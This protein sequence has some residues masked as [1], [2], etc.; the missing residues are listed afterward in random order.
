[1]CTMCSM[2]TARE[3]LAGRGGAW[4]VVVMGGCDGGVGYVGW[5]VVM[6]LGGVCWML[7]YIG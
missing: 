1:M 5:V 7:A 4:W 2:C 6:G 3:R